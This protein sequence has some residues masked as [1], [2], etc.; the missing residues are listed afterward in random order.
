M[1]SAQRLS[2]AEREQLARDLFEAEVCRA[3]TDVNAFI[4]LCF[5]N[6]Q[7][8]EFP[9]FEQQWFHKEWQ[10]AWSTHRKVVIHG[11]TGFGKTEQVIGHLLWRMGRKPTI[12]I[13]LLG[14]QQENAKRL[15]AKI[16]RQI[17]SNPLVRLVFPSLTPGVPWTDERLRLAEAGVDT[18]SNTIETY[19]LEGAPQ[20]ARADIVLADD[21]VDFENSLTEYQRKKLIAFIDQSIRTRLTTNGQFFLLANAWH[22]D[23][24]AFD[25]SRRAGIWYKAYP[26]ANDNGELLW[27]SFRTQAWLDHERDTTPLASFERMYLCKP[28]S[29]ETRI[30]QEAW[31]ALARKLGQGCRPV[32]A[33]AHAFDRKGKLLDPMKMA[34]AATMLAQRMRIVI[35]VDLATGKTERK[36]KSDLTVFF[37]L[38]ILPDGR[39]Q[40][41]WIEKGRWSVD[42]TLER[43]KLLEQRYQPEL[44]VVED[45][46]AQVFLAQ[47]ARGGAIKT[48]IMD[49]STGAAKWHESLGIEGIGAEMKAGRWLLPC[50]D[51]AEPANDYAE[52]LTP[53]ERE[54][55]VAINTWAAHLLD[56][57]RVGHTADDIMA[58]Y[59]AKQG[60]I[61]LAGGTFQHSHATEMVT[62]PPEHVNAQA[63][64]NWATATALLGAPAVAPSGWAAVQAAFASLPPVTAPAP[65]APA[66]PTVALPTPA[67]AP[68][69]APAT[70][71]PDYVRGLFRLAS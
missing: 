35:G 18:T 38:G 60:A 56:F 15:L 21:V 25:Y 13:L 55:Y 44:F 53:E 62:P 14:K 66:A 9:A 54:A 51:A 49:F 40:V 63:V 41:L 68:P 64:G 23:D 69:A 5:R 65:A 29:D 67:P 50:A 39:R 61:A 22:K 2:D 45:N 17:E 1:L 33:V 20:G 19:G 24:L 32:R 6:D 26:A 7:D 31:F 36:R 30:F 4:E 16:R 70:S 12:R 48:P 11:A 57:S 43:M 46:G 52:A 59:F 10:A 47:F 3:R 28:R 42:I 27:P 71:V 58:G 8:D 34:L 37:V